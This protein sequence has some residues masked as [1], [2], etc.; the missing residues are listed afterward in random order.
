[1]KRSPPHSTLTDTIIPNKTLFRY[2]LG[3]D[4]TNVEMLYPILPVEDADVSEFMSKE[5]TKPGMKIMPSTGVQKVTTGG[6]GVTAEI[7]SK[8]G[9]VTTD[10]FSHVIVAVGIVPNLEHLG[11]EELGIESDQRAHIKPDEYCRSH[12]PG[13]LGRAHV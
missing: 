12:F 4:V 3:A 9:K 8:D 7:K 5:L 10:E 2:E 6:K 13:M 1:M 11:L